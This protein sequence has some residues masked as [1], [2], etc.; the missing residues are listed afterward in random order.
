MVQADTKGSAV[1][2]SGGGCYNATLRTANGSVEVL[3]D[4]ERPKVWVNASSGL[5][6]LLF[7]ASGGAKQP[8]VK[9]GRARGFT[10]VQ[11]IRTETPPRPTS[12][13]PVD[14]ELVECS[15]AE[16]LNEL[17]NVEQSCAAVMQR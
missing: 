16:P 14:Y 5:P 17:V 8:T 15:K 2:G 4:A 10:V 6:T 3:Q 7:Y 12:S 9:D 1:G 11:R 13:S